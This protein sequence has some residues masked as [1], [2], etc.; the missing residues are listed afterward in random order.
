LGAQY[1][2]RHT[3]VPGINNDDAFGFLD[4]AYRRY[5][6]EAVGKTVALAYATNSCVNEWMVLPGNNSTRG[7]ELYLGGPLRREAQLLAAMADSADNFART[8]YKS[9]TGSE[10]NLKTAIYS[11]GQFKWNGH[12]AVMERLFKTE[13]LR[14]LT[15]STHRSRLLSDAAFRWR[16]ANAMLAA[17]EGDL[18]AI[19]TLL[20]TALEEARESQLLYYLNYDDD[21]TVGSKGAE[22]TQKL[23]V[24]CNQFLENTR[25][26]RDQIGEAKTYPPESLRALAT[27]QD[28]VRWE[29]MSDIL[30]PEPR[31]NDGQVCIVTYLGLSDPIDYFCLGTVFTI[32]VYRNSHWQTTFRRALLKKDSGWQYWEVPLGIGEEFLGETLRL[33]FVTD[34]YSRA[35]DS[36]WPS[37]KWGF[38]GQPQL[39]QYQRNNRTKVLYD[40]SDQS[41]RSR[42][43]VVLD[44]DGAERPF[45]AEAEDSTGAT[46]RVTTQDAYR[47][48]N[49]PAPKRPAIAAFSPHKNGLFGITIAEFIL[50]ALG[51]S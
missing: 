42:R 5:Y 8:A 7:A 24:I 29:K 15:V 37:W 27:A 47:G 30:P 13:R 17:G 45:D 28:C 41:T 3:G 23:T 9:F 16:K 39:V 22:V 36:A 50:A 49:T 1:Q 10:P 18:A 44:K 20:S 40:F 34:N 12:D 46:F 6:G 19:W 11:S 43:M 48:V 32:E 33:R 35:F 21:Y 4:Y 31:R 2:W 38:W 51:K 26:T 14:L 25:L